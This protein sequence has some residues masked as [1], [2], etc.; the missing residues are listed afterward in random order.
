VLDAEVHITSREITLATHAKGIFPTLEEVA[1][2]ASICYSGDTL[3]Q[4]V[5]ALW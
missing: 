5:S 3:A 4:P 1:M 2:I